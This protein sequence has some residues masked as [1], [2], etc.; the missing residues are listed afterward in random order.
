MAL[1][2][3]RSPGAPIREEEYTPF[4]LRICFHET[5]QKFRLD[6]VDKVRHSVRLPYVSGCL[7]F[8]A[9]F[10]VNVIRYLPLA[11]I[12]VHTPSTLVVHLAVLA[13]TVL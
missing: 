1:W 12:V 3:G 11:F 6:L 7:H 4:K 8:L 9:L 2:R 13:V 5:I 10:T